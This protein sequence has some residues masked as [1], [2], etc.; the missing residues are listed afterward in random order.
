[1]T[2]KDRISVQCFAV[3]YWEHLRKDDLT[4]VLSVVYV[5]FQFGIQGALMGSAE[6]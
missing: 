1:M 5:L 6:A 2:Q 4:N 3:S